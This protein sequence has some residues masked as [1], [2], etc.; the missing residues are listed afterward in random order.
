MSSC[1]VLSASRSD[2][3]PSATIYPNSHLSGSFSNHLMETIGV[4]INTGSKDGSCIRDTL[5][6]APPPL[7]N[8]IP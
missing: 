2:I 6:T 7:S 1:S 8:V 5:G 3:F 4:R